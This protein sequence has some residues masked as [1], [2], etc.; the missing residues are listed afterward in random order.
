MKN[1]FWN[2]QQ[3][4]LRTLW[5]LTGQMLLL[6]ALSSCL[7]AAFLLPGMIATNMP[8]QIEETTL[9]AANLMLLP[10]TLLSVW[11]AGRFLDRRRFADFGMRLSRDWL[12]EL[13]A[14]LALGVL[15]MA[16]IFLVEWAAGWVAV[17]GTLRA[18]GFGGSFPL[19]VAF[20]VLLYLV[21]G[22]Y[23]E[24][25]FRGYFLR[26]LAEGLRLPW[27]GKRGA[28]LLS[29]VLTSLVFG[30]A[31]ALN[32]NAS[33][34]STL[35]IAL[36]GIF[37]GLGYVLSGNLALPIGLHITW[38]FFQ[39]TVFGFPVSGGAATTSFVVIEQGGPALW[40]GGAFGP[41][42]GLIGILAMLAGCAA[43]AGW[44]R[45]RYGRV[46]LQETLAE[47]TPRASRE[48]ASL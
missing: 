47:Y 33:V 29:W 35:N 9:R 22:I 16:A 26:N 40:T 20:D 10:A 44:M 42:A 1:P 5:R 37:L 11:F 36:A 8:P 7:S 46:A 34:V 17:V 31:H 14:G 41:E 18:G 38:N 39:G 6:I 15:L 13:L 27:L 3:R 21:V 43:I 30:A 32:P 28:L 48:L 25:L 19:A 24:V 12:L 2:A 23:E 4:R 45:W